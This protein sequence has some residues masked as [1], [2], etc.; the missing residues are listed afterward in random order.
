MRKRSNT[1]LGLMWKTAA[2]IT[3][4]NNRCS[5]S[6]RH[7]LDH[8]ARIKAALMFKLVKED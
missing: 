3:G 1:N 8:I 7:D 5:I 2:S 4:V 6:T